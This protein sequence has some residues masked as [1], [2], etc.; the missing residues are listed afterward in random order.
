MAIDP[1]LARDL[2]ATADMRLGEDDAAIQQRQQGRVEPR[3]VD[4]L[5]GA[6]AVEQAR[7]GAVERG[8]AMAGDDDGD[9]PGGLGAGTG[10]GT[11]AG[12]HH[13]AHVVRRVMAGDLA[14]MAQGALGG[15]EVDV[16]PLGGRGERRGDDGDEGCR[17]VVVA[18]EVQGA[19][20][21]VRADLEAQATVGL[22]DAD[23]SLAV[24]AL[25]GDQAVAEGEDIVDALAGLV[26]LAGV[27]D[28]QPVVADEAELRLDVVG[29]REPAIEDA[30][31]LHGVLDPRRATAHR[32]GS[33]RRL[34]GRDDVRLGGIA[35]CRRDDD[36]RAAAGALDLELE[37][38]VGLGEHEGAIT[39]GN[40]DPPHL[41]RPVEVVGK[42]VEEGASIG[43][44]GTAVV[45]V[46]HLDGEV[47][48][49]RQVAEA[50]RVELGTGEID[51]IGEESIV[52]AGLD[53]TGRGVRLA[54]GPQVEQGLV[55]TITDPM[56]LRQL[57][58]GRGEVVVGVGAVLPTGRALS[59]GSASHEFVEDGVSRQCG[60]AGV[61]VGA[62]GSEVRRH[63]LVG[64]TEPG[65][66]IGPVLAGG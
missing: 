55:V 3:I 10:V 8:A 62:F 44:P 54:V 2:A 26:A 18:T 1:L 5:V 35:R 9:A 22:E 24:P 61:V 45:G 21:L 64:V 19:A 42:R 49:G 40:V 50:Q 27:E 12:V 31:V 29:D 36:P 28:H 57:V 33:A 13:L 34:I 46:G 7:G 20:R 51:G 4:R 30:V 25:V 39:G 66:G 43:R 56:Q 65:V 15:G 14:T 17:G 6:V 47:E 58:P 37:A 16:P 63:R 60:G 41:V 48:A 53:D 52:R 38:L 11:G 59:G 32:D 23:A